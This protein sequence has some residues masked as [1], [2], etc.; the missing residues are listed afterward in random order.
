MQIRGGRGYETEKSL[1]ARGEQPIGVERMMRDYRINKIFEG[2]TRDHAPLHGPRDGG[3]APRGGGGHDRPR[4]ADVGQAGRPAEDGRV[5]RRL[6]PDA[7]AGLGTLAA[8]L[9]LRRPG[10]PSALRRAERAQARARRA[11]TACCATRRSCRTSRPSCSA[12][13]TSPTSC[14]RW[15]RRSRARAP[16]PTQ[17]RPEAAEARQLADLFCRIARR[18]VG[19]SSTRC[20]TTTTSSSTARAWRS[21][22][23]ATSGSSR[24]SWG[25]GRR[26]LRRPRGGG[27]GAEEGRGR[28]LSRPAS[29]PRNDLAPH[30]RPAQ[31]RRVAEVLEAHLL[32]VG[33]GAAALRTAEAADELTLRHVEP[34]EQAV[35]ARP[36]CVPPWHSPT[37]PT[38]RRG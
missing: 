36:A 26:R 7:L 8:L 28:R 18:R 10:H 32:E 38:R 15:R 1:A 12:W 14:S 34:A 5:L 33:P 21:W 25:W 35:A 3:Q 22:T 27:S 37:W 17:Q 19:R 9:G 29:Q 2:S 23:A 16:W 30:H 31:R 20:G 13:W 6:V 24:A 4:Q 11:S